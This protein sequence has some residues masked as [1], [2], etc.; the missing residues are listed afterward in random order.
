MLSAIEFVNQYFN[1]PIIAL[2][3]FAIIWLIINLIGEILEF[4]GK[5][6]PEFCK[7]RKYFARK[8]HERETIAKVSDMMGDVQK[9]LSD[10]D[11]HYSE[12]NIA[13]RDEWIKD[14]NDRLDEHDSHMKKIDVKLDE[15]KEHISNIDRK[16]DS[17]E[18]RIDGIDKK[19]DKLA[20]TVDNLAKEVHGLNEKV[21]NGRIEDQKDKI[22]NFAYRV[23][24]P[25]A[26]FAQEAFNNIFDVYKEYE[27][28]VEETGR[29][30]GK[31]E[32]SYQII[33]D[34]YKHR[35][36]THTFAEDIR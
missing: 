27:R 12:D 21:I 29:T 23:N 33:I 1:I 2:A 25:N 16:L 7:M 9:L 13:K 20:D 18:R 11:K 15:H 30:N 31:V 8:R 22:I 4:K 36:E 35:M 24:D 5:I 6:V 19:I 26:R 3:V 10:V 14:V 32:V 34:A 17:H 28:T